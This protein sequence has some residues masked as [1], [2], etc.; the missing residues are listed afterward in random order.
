MDELV[1]YHDEDY[2]EFLSQAESNFLDVDQD[3]LSSDLL[4]QR[5]EFG[6]I[7]LI[8]FFLSFVLIINKRLED[9]C[10][11]FEGLFQYIK[12]ISGA[13]IQ[14]AKEL[15]QKRSKIAIN[16]E[17]GRHHAKKL[18]LSFFYFLPNL[19]NH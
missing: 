8:F 15:R 4:E 2:I 17:G 18:F 1:Q 10:P 6:F 3:E 9:D 16:W 14:G 12:F 13:T 5:E 19:P 7:F 11:I